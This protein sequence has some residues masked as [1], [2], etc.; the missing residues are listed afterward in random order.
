MG[1]DH[2]EEQDQQIGGERGNTNIVADHAEQRW[3]QADPHIGAGH[4]Y[5]DDR[6]A[7]FAPKCRGVEWITHG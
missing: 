5:A 2:K 6:L 1:Q 4:L 3:H 7:L